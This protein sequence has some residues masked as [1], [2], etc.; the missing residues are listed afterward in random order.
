MCNALNSVPMTDSSESV[1]N[2]GNKGRTRDND[3]MLSTWSIT[4]CIGV[5]MPLHQSVRLRLQGESF[6]KLNDIDV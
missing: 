5:N 2:S 3:C 4:S 6:H 1:E